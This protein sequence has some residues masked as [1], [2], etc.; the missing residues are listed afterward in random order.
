MSF[1]FNSR[2]E[3]VSVHAREGG[4]PPM[5]AGGSPSQIYVAVETPPQP[6]HRGEADF[7]A[8]RRT[9]C[10]VEISFTAVC[11]LWGGCGRPW[12][13]SALGGLLEPSW[14]A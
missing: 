1:F 5:G 10:I 12:L 4:F 7:N 13:W 3:R 2:I 6:A 14:S 9:N 11:W 8:V